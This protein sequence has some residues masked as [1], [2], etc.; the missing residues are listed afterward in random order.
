MTT[1]ITAAI[2]T[3][4]KL[5]T[6][7]KGLKRNFLQTYSWTRISISGLRRDLK[8]KLLVSRKNLLR[9]FGGQGKH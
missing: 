5:V 3:S 9:C 8:L 6:R 4:G 1:Q 2:E 7:K